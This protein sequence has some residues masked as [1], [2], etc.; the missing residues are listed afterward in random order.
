ME[1]PVM[2]VNM[3][4]SPRGHGSERVAAALGLRFVRRCSGGE[5]GAVLV[6]DAAGVSAILKVMPDVPPW[7]GAWGAAVGLAER[8]RAAG[9]PAPR[10]LRDGTAA[11]HV[12]TLQ[13]VMPG[14]VPTWLTAGHVRQ[15]LALAERHAGMAGGE[16][17]LWQSY[18]HAV[19]AGTHGPERVAFA[20]A[21]HPDAARLLDEI[22]ALAPRLAGLALPEGDVVHGDLH[23]QNVLVE[24]DRVTAVF[25]WEQATAGDWR[26]DVAWLAFWCRVDRDQVDAVG[27]ELA[28]RRAAELL[29]P[30]ER[31]AYAG[32]AAFRVI[33][34]IAHHRRQLL[35]RAL[36]W[37]EAH[38]APLWR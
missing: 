3:A 31:A 1:R 10:Y 22:Q 34:L 33:S 15:L 6:E 23:H 37:C 26:Y 9:Y 28:D 27:A 38:L 2:G 12:Y 32:V 24:G 36:R 13:E 18:V 11:G 4:T 20:R 14:A 19:L 7:S 25:D 29:T 5:F 16:P 21:S 35:P 30:P 8:L 17:S